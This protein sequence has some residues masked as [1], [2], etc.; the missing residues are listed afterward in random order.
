VPLSQSANVPIF[1]LKAQHGVVGA[2][3][4]KVGE[5]E[6]IIESVASKFAQNLQ[7]L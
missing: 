5:Y 2:H 1:A 7:A 3:F 6:G 4:V